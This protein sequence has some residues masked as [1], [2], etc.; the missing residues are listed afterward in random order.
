MPNTTKPPKAKR[1][2]SCKTLFQPRNSLVVVCSPV[3]AQ[4][5]AQVNREKAEKVAK[6][7][8]RKADAV[9]REK[10][11]SRSKWLS[12]AQAIANKY[13]RVRDANDGCISCNKPASWDG[14]WHGSHFRSVGAASAVRLNLWNIHKACSVCN[15]Y[16]SGNISEYTPRLIKKIGLEKVEW[17]KT[18]NQLVKYEVDYLKR[19]KRVIGKR[20]RRME[21][22]HVLQS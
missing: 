5:V 10:L 9:K 15:N 8:E 1:C 17:L 12:E 7:A 16:L 18:Q 20:L 19:Y 4:V 11:K 6:S 2:R 21:E 22:R 3:C 14:Q 13:A